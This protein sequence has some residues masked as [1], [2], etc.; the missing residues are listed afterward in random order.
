MIFRMRP[1]FLNPGRAFLQRILEL[2]VQDLQHAGKLALL[3]KRH[4]IEGRFHHGREI[5]RGSNSNDLKKLRRDQLSFYT[6]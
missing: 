3:A 5:F 2:L 4:M 6:G 1:R